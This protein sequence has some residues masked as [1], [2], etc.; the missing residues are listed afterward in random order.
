MPYAQSWGH[1]FVASQTITQSLTITVLL[2]SP[3]LER[4][5][6]QG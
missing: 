4:E 6:K 3:E 2:H 1:D 5:E